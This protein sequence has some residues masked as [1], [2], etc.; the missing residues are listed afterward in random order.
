MGGLERKIELME[1][2]HDP[3]IKIEVNSFDDFDHD[4]NDYLEWEKRLD[5]FFKHESTP[6][7]KRFKMAKS[8]LTKW[9]K[10]W[11]D[12]VQKQR[13]RE[14]KRKIS[15]SPKRKD[16][17]RRKYVSPNFKPTSLIPQNTTPKMTTRVPT[18]WK[19]K[20]HHHPQISL[21]KLASA[22]RMKRF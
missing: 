17:L 16:K 14:G 9:A 20:S 19:P 7:E 4:S 3:G 18:F 5:R 22:R 10:S 11:L 12:G 13:L 15:E 1:K 2:P 8:K 21:T 6:K